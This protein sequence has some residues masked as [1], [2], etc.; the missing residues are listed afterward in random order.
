MR[1]NIPTVVG[2]GLLGTVTDITTTTI[3][4]GVIMITRGESVLTRTLSGR[5][6]QEKIELSDTKSW[7]PTGWLAG[8]LAGR[9]FQ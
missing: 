4:D 7:H 2:P 6:E 9:G 1:T 5:S 8:W 3:E